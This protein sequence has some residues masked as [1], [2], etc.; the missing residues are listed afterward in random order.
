[1]ETKKVQVI[2]AILAAIIIAMSFFQTP[3][4]CMLSIGDSIIPRLIYHFFHA[5]PFHALINCLCIY[6]LLYK[7][8]V[9]AWH[10]PAAYTIAAAVPAWALSTTPTIGL[11]GICFAL[12]GL[13]TF[14]VY[15][16]LYFASYI[17]AFLLVS[18]ILP[19]LM[20]ACGLPSA[21]PNTLLHLYCYAAGSILSFFTAPLWNR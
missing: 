15:R 21:R 10:Y 4:C 8:D 20:N 13:Q 11:S 12:I 19:F 17:L 7:Y 1:M 9:P 2:T 16:K 14:L 5:N 6:T 18:S 3:P